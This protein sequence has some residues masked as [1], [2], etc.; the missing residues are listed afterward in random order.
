MIDDC[1]WRTTYVWW[2]LDPPAACTT[3]IKRVKCEERLAGDQHARRVR[4]V[5]LLGD[6]AEAR[7]EGWLGGG[8]GARRVGLR[9]RRLGLDETLDHG[10]R[11]AQAT[12]QLLAAAELLDQRQAV[13]PRVALLVDVR[14]RAHQR[15]QNNLCVILKEVY[16]QTK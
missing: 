1:C 4:L 5:M 13:R 10:A 16:L 15:T 12:G 2:K 6:G 14:T 9:R 3:C 11:V 8:G 7:R